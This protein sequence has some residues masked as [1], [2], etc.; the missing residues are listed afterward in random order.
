M[1]T[2]LIN[3]NFKNHYLYN[4]LS[5]RGIQNIEDFINPQFTIQN[6]DN[7]DNIVE[8]SNLFY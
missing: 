6:P 2:R 4:L 7:F 8:G 3:D 5:S 1:K